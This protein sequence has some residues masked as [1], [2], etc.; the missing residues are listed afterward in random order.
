MEANEIDRL[1][2][3]HASWLSALLRGMTR[4]EAD[5]E[6]AFQDVWLRLMK[7][8]SL[9]SPD[10]MRSYLA[11]TA[12]AVVVDRYRKTKHIEL[13]LDSAAG[14]SLVTE[15]ADSS[16][17]PGK[18]FESRATHEDVMRAVRALP[19]GPRTVVLMRVEA[20][21]TF[22]EIADSLEMPLGTVLTWMR[23]ATLRLKENLEGKE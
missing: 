19:E 7:V 11:R 17:T 18:R 8:A 20:E 14:E 2:R 3:E 10:A 1:V 9:P 6:D 13:S 16:P 4:C 12:R 23:T 22:Q 21:L 15:I 5:A